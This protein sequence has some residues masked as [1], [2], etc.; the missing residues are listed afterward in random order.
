MPRMLD[1]PVYYTDVQ[2]RALKSKA[3]NNHPSITPRNAEIIMETIRVYDAILKDQNPTPLPQF[4]DS[5]TYD[6]RQVNKFVLYNRHTKH[7]HITVMS[8]CY[9]PKRRP[10]ARVGKV[11]KQ[12]DTTIKPTRDP[13]GSTFGF[14]RGAEVA[15]VEEEKEVGESIVV[16]DKTEGG[17]KVS[18]K[19][20]G[21]AG[22]K[23]LAEK[24]RSSRLKAKVVASDDFVRRSSRRIGGAATVSADI[25]MD[26]GTPE[27]QIMTREMSKLADCSSPGSKEGFS[28]R[29]ELVSDFNVTYGPP[30]S[31]KSPYSHPKLVYQSPY[32]PI[33][34]AY[35]NV[36]SRETTISAP[37]TIIPDVEDQFPRI[38]R[39]A[40]LTITPDAG[41]HSPSR[42]T[43]ISYPPV[44][45]PDINDQFPSR[46]TTAS[47]PGS[48]ISDAEDQ[49]PSGDT[50]ISY[51]SQ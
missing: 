34:D 16:E 48:V 43:T 11:P 38:N 10:E 46:Q 27:P 9:L 35:E 42:N 12:V 39:S 6:K 15:V 40:P 29:D 41:N 47:A 4:A 13:R 25:D 37:P 18:I 28:E 49:L 2:W 32:A 45:I 30:I 50:T 1:L 23:T 22:R 20:S 14:I 8:P 51:I 17:K 36:A 5:I 33:P 24:K 3:R 31:Y 19:K 44:V 21:P 7:D 26:A